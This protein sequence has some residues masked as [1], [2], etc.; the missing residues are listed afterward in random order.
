MRERYPV[1]VFVAEALES[2]GLR[3]KYDARPPYQRNDYVG[4]I[5]RAKRMETK[6]RRLEQMLE[7]LEVGDRYMKMKWGS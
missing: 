4:W 7:E 1:P 6:L 3:A 2:R 5:T